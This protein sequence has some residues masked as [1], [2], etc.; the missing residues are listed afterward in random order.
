MPR[1]VVVAERV[2]GGNGSDDRDGRE[3]GSEPGELLWRGV[4]KAHV[5]DLRTSIQHGHADP[6][7]QAHHANQG[8]PP[9][10][11]EMVHPPQHVLQRWPLRVLQ[12]R[13]E[14]RQHGHRGMCE[15][16][17]TQNAAERDV[18]ARQEEDE[19]VADDVAQAHPERLVDRGERQ[20]LARQQLDRPSST[21]TTS[22]AAKHKTA[23]NSALASAP[24]LPETTS[25][26]AVAARMPSTSPLS[27]V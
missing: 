10:A 21:A 15:R 18:E 20:V 17:G 1:A 23:T 25:C 16:D 12:V 2:R 13:E 4:R 3:E 26:S 19:R 9:S 27:S 24:M 11:R 6:L 8:R 14:R 22:C 5:V 7:Q